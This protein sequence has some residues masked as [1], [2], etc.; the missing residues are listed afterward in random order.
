Y[1]ASLDAPQGVAEADKVALGQRIYRGGIADIG[2]AACAACHSPTGSGNSAAGFPALSG[3]DPAYVEVQ[4]KAFRAKQR[5]NDN[6][7]VMRA[8]AARLNDEEI[9][10]LA[11]YVSGLR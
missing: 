2:V 11:S 7:A 8:L 1:F 4:L 9:S 10:A 3:Q 5:E 6:A